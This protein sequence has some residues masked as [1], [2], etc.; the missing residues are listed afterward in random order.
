MKQDEGV[1]ELGRDGER[2]EAC[3]KVRPVTG[4]VRI[5]DLS[6]EGSVSVGE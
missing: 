2:R 6:L 5:Q 1:G 4:V 3:R